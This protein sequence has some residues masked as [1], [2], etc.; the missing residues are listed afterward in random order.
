MPV[1]GYPLFWMFGKGA[2]LSKL[3]RDRFKDDFAHPEKVPELINK[4]A[5][6]MMGMIILLVMVITFMVIRVTY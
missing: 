4:Y 3:K 6:I 2:M 1:I 5:I